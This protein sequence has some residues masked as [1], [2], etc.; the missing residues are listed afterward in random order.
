MKYGNLI[1]EKREYVLL[2]KLMNLSKYYKDVTL[3]KSM[4]KLSGEIESATIC[5][6]KDMPNDVIRFNST[7]TVVSE[8]GWSKKFTLVTPAES[9]IEHGK[10]SLL[11]P[12][13]SAVIGYAEGD[14]IIWE[15]P[16]GE[17]HLTIGNVEQGNQKLN[18]SM[19]L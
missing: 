16:S 9:N 6:E 13:G 2:K 7:I 1:I 19:V 18:V 14:T 17:Q 11:T 12:M 15:F 5:D 4:K 3:G 8:K 10:I